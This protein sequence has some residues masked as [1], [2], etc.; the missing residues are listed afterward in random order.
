MNSLISVM[1]DPTHVHT[2]SDAAKF[3]Q[4][5]LARSAA[6]QRTT[7]VGGVGDGEGIRGPAAPSGRGMGLDGGPA[8]K[9]QCSSFSPCKEGTAM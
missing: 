7:E 3:A 5:K 9:E 4:T 2:A 1:L 8:H 6:A